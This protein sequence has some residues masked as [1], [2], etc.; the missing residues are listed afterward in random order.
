[1]LF[2]LSAATTILL[3]L[4]IRCLGLSAL[5]SSIGLGFRIVFVVSIGLLYLAFR[6]TNKPSIGNLTG[7][8]KQYAEVNQLHISWID[9]NIKTL[10]DFGRF[11]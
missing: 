10:D 5:E 8:W 1:M 9:E 11:K 4:L 3:E 2:W 6:L 7:V